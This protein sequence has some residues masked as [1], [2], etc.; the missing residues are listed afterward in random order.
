MKRICF[1]NKGKDLCPSLY[2]I[3]LHK[4]LF[5]YLGLLF[6]LFLSSFLSIRYGGVSDLSDTSLASLI[7]W[8][9]RYPRLL[10][11]IFSGAALSLAGYI[12]Q[13]VLKNPLTDPYILG[14]SSGGALGVGIF[15]IF[16]PVYSILGLQ[17]SSTLGAVVALSFL[18][19]ISRKITSNS[20]VSIILIGVGLSLLFSSLTSIIMSYMEGGKLVYMN[21]WLTGSVSQA[22]LP[23]LYVFA[24]ILIL[25]S[26]LIFMFSNSLDVLKF[27]ED[28]SISTGLNPR[29]YTLLFLVLAS[30]LTAS[31]VAVCGVIGFV[32]LVVPHIAR[33][34][35]KERSFAMIPI[36]MILGAGFLTFCNFIAGALSFNI[37]V[38]IGAVSSFIG[39]PLL[40]YLIFRRYRAGA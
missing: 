1:F 25:I 2:F 32:G 8:E 16:T 17:V 33:L 29:F 13:S 39:A 9:L 36:V 28:F 15:L 3:S 11:S 6:F 19:L 4:K 27:G 37:D 14:I 31:S 5:I 40:I 38:P 20:S 35:I 34:L 7:M 21:H 26:T 10:A 18:L 30:V 24:F 22:E 12:F 23:E